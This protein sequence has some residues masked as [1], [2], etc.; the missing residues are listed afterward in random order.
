MSP[1]PII[2]GDTSVSPHFRVGSGAGGT[3][4]RSSGSINKTRVRVESFVTGIPHGTGLELSRAELAERLSLFPNHRQRRLRGS[5]G[6]ESPSGDLRSSLS[7]IFSNLV[8][9]IRF[10][11]LIKFFRTFRSH[12]FLVIF[13]FANLLILCC[14]QAA[15]GTGDSSA[16]Y[17]VPPRWGPSRMYGTFREWVQQLML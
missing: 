4:L 2:L 17:R 9:T 15:G 5:A 1:I 14:M 8:H 7:T 11:T 13:I 12:L 10:F 3:N 16:T 6:T